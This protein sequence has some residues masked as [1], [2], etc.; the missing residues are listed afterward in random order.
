MSAADLDSRLSF[1]RSAERL[2]DTLRS[3]YTT[4]GR[5]E[6][7][8]DHSW[9]LT[10]VAM[11]FL[12]MLPDLDAL[13][14]IKLCVIHD[15]GEAIGGDIPAPDQPLVAAKSAQ[16]RRDFQTLIAPLPHALRQ[17]FTAL[18]DEYE[19]AESPEARAVKAL[20]KIETILQHNQGSNPPDF[21]YG[22]NLDYGRRYTEQLEL[23]RDIRALLDRDTERNRR[24][25]RSSAG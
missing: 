24:G 5:T 7:A 9:R 20:D 2:K 17:E 14:V 21:D 10:L 22:F 23:T 3:A 25:S 8:A 12:D 13:R 6:S 11:V 4:S 16:E 15:L 19:A 1:L 18:W